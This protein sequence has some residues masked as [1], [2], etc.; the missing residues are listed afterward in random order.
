MLPLILAISATSSA[1]GVPGET[2]YPMR[3]LVRAHVHSGD[4]VCFE[5]VRR[6]PEWTPMPPSGASLEAEV[7]AASAQQGTRYTIVDRPACRLV[8]ADGPLLLDTMVTLRGGKQSLEEAVEEWDHA[9]EAAVGLPVMVLTHPVGWR[10]DVPGGTMTA[11][12]ALEAMVADV[13][14][15]L[16]WSVVWMD[17]SFFVNGPPDEK[18]RWILNIVS[19]KGAEPEMAPYPIPDL[20]GNEPGVRALPGGRIEYFRTDPVTGEEVILK[21]EQLPERAP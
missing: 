8:M 1:G 19:P 11:R 13:G 5:D 10:V 4:A 14:V 7:G 12:A 3:D 21:V 2:V 18:G 9:L 20:K 6:P 17:A 15:P 16:V